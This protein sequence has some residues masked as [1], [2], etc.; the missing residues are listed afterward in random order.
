MNI[1]SNFI[2]TL[3]GIQ[4]FTNLRILSIGYN[5]IS[6]LSELRFLVDLPLHILTME[7]NP[8]AS[9]PF[10]R[11]HVLFTVPTLKSFDGKDVKQKDRT[12]SDSILAFDNQRLTELCL[13]AIKLSSL[14]SLSVDNQQNDIRW[15][16]E[17]QRVIGTLTLESFGLSE[18]E[19]TANFDQMRDVAQDL[20]RERGLVNWRETYSAIETRQKKAMDEL[21]N[22]IQPRIQKIKPLEI[23]KQLPKSPVAGAESRK[24]IFEFSSPK[25][26]SPPTQLQATP[27]IR[28][29]AE[30]ISLI[31]PLEFDLPAVAIRM[32][33]HRKMLRVFLSWFGIIKESP[34]LNHLEKVL[35]N[36]HSRLVLLRRFS[37]WKCKTLTKRR[38]FGPKHFELLEKAQDAMTR[39]SE[40]EDELESRRRSTEDVRGALEKAV[41]N[42]TKLKTVIQRKNGENL[43]LKQ[44][45][46]ESEKKY[47]DE[48]LR[49]I[50]DA[51]F[52]F[53]LD[54]ER[55][56]QLEKEFTKCEVDKSA[57]EKRIQEGQLAHKQEVA[58]LQ[59]K[60]Q[61]A[62]EVTSGFR[63]E[64]SKLQTQVESTSARSSPRQVS[65]FEL[66]V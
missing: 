11:F 65:Q 23:P 2:P 4:H 19:I 29:P 21:M 31:A 49:Y 48:V 50:L 7:G 26:H 56:K 3:D 17:V 5:I 10:Y 9:L 20:R 34:L 27:P 39:I 6:K 37:M 15:L 43:M 62:F 22:Q 38:R 16:S 18:D 61:S 45:L 53:E 14:R 51:K 35:R 30:E 60:L 58:Q 1:S 36:Q 66:N 46:A 57:L 55:M 25:N 52:Q 47:E 24:L 54:E 12:K 44:N 33:E 32:T 59:E 28:S 13:N 42:E 40:L 8:I 41:N 63:R 64:V